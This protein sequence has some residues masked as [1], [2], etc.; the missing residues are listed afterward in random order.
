M[1]YSEAFKEFWTLYLP[2]RAFNDDLL[3]A[4]AMETGDIEFFKHFA[5]EHAIS[6]L[7][8][9][10][11]SMF[12][13]YARANDSSRFG[14]SEGKEFIKK[15]TPISQKIKECLYTLKEGSFDLSSGIDRIEEKYF[16]PEHYPYYR[17]HNLKT[18]A[19]QPHGVYQT[20]QEINTVLI[21]YLSSE[22]F[23]FQVFILNKIKDGTKSITRPQY[24][25]LRFELK[26]HN[27]SMALFIK[28]NWPVIERQEWLDV[29]SS[30]KL[31]RQLTLDHIKQA[32]S[33]SR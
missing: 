6:A 19:I 22:K 1:E 20:K 8:A 3:R 7:D 9:N 5:F 2:K 14:N 16:G 23:L 30:V 11:S 25:E 17:D 4:L 12:D 31:Y 21:N 32:E 24:A 29:H 28:N 26:T 18:N 33:S 13:P 10:P 27:D 15:I